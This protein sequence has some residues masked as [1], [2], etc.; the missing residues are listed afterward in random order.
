M[1]EDCGPEW[2]GLTCLPVHTASPLN[3]RALNHLRKLPLF[4]F[5]LSTTSKISEFTPPCGFDPSECLNHGNLDA[6]TPFIRLGFDQLMGSRKILKTYTTLDD[7]TTLDCIAHMGR[8]NVCH[9]SLQIQNFS[10]FV[11]W[12]TRY[13]LGDIS[14]RKLW[15]HFAL[16][17]LLCGWPGSKEI[18]EPARIYAI[19]SQR[20]PLDVSST[21]DT[22][23]PPSQVK[24]EEQIVNHLRIVVSTGVGSENIRGIAASEPILSEAAYVVMKDPICFNLPKALSRILLE[25]YAMD[26]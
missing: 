5:F 2:A 10:H 25:G 15:V 12:G 16:Q 8:T 26:S 14:V 6:P 13:D 9:V 20:L 24:Q 11:R 21:V 3:C 22:P 23:L 17:K 18:V 4:T 1:S 7:V 19:L